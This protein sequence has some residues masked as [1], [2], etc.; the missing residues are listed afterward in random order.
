MADLPL[1][2]PLACRWEKYGFRCNN[3]ANLHTSF[4]TFHDEKPG[5]TPPAVATLAAPP[6]T[7]KL[8]LDPSTAAELNPSTARQLE[9]VQ[10]AYAD[11]RKAICIQISDV[12][13]NE[14]ISFFMPAEK[15]RE[16]GFALQRLA[17]FVNSGR[18]ESLGNYRKFTGSSF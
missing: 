18:V 5:T 2:N 14:F 6:A 13:G 4:C 7:A 16:I 3:R 9:L 1:K 17:E 8:E 15:A 10:V 12:N 11:G